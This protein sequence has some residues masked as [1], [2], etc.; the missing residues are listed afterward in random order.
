MEVARRH[1]PQGMRRFDPSDPSG[2]PAITSEVTSACTVVTAADAR[3]PPADGNA[4]PAPPDHFTGPLHRTHSP[5][6]FT[7]PIHRGRPG[8]AGKSPAGWCRQLGSAQGGST[9]DL[10]ALMFLTPVPQRRVQSLAQSL[11]HPAA[12]S[13]RPALS[14]RRIGATRAV[15][16]RSPRSG[17]RP[18]FG[19]R[20]RGSVRSDDSGYRTIQVSFPRSRFCRSPSPLRAMAVSI[21]AL[22]ADS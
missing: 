12:P 18:L 10:R 14:A 4:S 5:D 13:A 7:G 2:V 19:D 9:T 22:I 20:H 8:C 6:Q 21:C 3:L 17:T 15:G 16:P 11:A 1:D